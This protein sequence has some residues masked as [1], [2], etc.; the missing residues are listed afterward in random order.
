MSGADDRGVV[1][2]GALAGRDCVRAPGKAMLFGEYAVLEGGTALVAAVDRYATAWLTSPDDGI[3]DS[4]FVRAARAVVLAEFQRRGLSAR[5]SGLRIDSTPLYQGGVGGRKLGLGSSAAVTVAAVGDWPDLPREALWR[6][7]QQAHAQAQGTPGSGADVAA[8][9][10]GGVIR[11]QAGPEAGGCTVSELRLDPDLAVTLVDS[12]VS[13]ATAPRLERLA[14]LKQDRPERYRRVMDPL[15]TLA[16]AVASQAERQGTIDPAAVV[17]WN[18]ALEALGAAVELPIMTDPLRRI[19]ACAE[20]VGG[21]GKPSGAGGGDLA[22]CFTARAE[23]DRLR[24]RLLEAGF[25]PLAVSVGARGLHRF[26][27]QPPAPPGARE[28]GP[29]TQPGGSS[30]ERAGHADAP[31]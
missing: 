4:P 31:R 7:C 21:A 29:S 3:G 27:D 12:G 9:I 26:H 10:W 13:A 1:G 23:A 14:A 8:A 18:R 25:E 15:L 16:Q 24:Q 20:A 11:F 2:G 30:Q 28:R 19:A 17:S 6:M 5:L 22:V